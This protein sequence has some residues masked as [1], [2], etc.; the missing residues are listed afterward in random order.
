MYIPEESN[1]IAQ[2]YDRYTQGEALLT[3]SLSLAASSISI[4]AGLV[5][6]YFFL[7]ID[8]K[9][10]V[11]RHQLIILMTYD[12]IKAPFFVIIPNEVIAKESLYYDLKCC[13][14]VGSFTT[15]SIEGSDLVILSFAIPVLF[16]VYVPQSKLHNGKTFE[17]GLYGVRYLVYAVSFLLPNVLVSLAFVYKRYLPLTN[18]C[19]IASTSLDPACVDWGPLYFIVLSIFIIYGSIYRHVVNKYNKLKSSIPAS[20]GTKKQRA[21]FLWKIYDF[22]K[23]MLFQ[24]VFF[25]DTFSKNTAIETSNQ[26]MYAKDASDVREPDYED[27]NQETL[28]L[29][30]C[31]KSQT[32]KHMRA[33][34]LCFFVDYPSYRACA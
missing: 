31:G 10:K 29:F 7:A 11:F 28:E 5:G 1:T 27:L 33:S 30:G 14:V 16:L 26:S 17:G 3:L 34:V 6:I 20:S 32:E 13:R 21:G 24:K 4:L 23:I 8:G 9:E 25:S 12:F 2:Y 15:F 19:Y 22:I 18:W